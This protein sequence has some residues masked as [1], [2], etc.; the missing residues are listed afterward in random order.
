MRGIIVHNSDVFWQPLTNL[1]IYYGETTV[2]PPLEKALRFMRHYVI[3]CK[4]TNDVTDTMNW[5]YLFHL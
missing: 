2:F 5:I 1:E 4:C 3:L